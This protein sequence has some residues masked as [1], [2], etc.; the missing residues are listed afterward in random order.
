[1]P[2][3]KDPARPPLE[4]QT[5]FIPEP[6]LRYLKSKWMPLQSTRS[7][8]GGLAHLIHL[9]LHWFEYGPREA[10]LLSPRQLVEF[11]AGKARMIKLSIRM[12]STDLARAR[13]LWSKE[14]LEGRFC[15]GFGVWLP[16]LAVIFNAGF[17]LAD[18]R[19]LRK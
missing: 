13:E 3:L 1:M 5:V 17:D 2:R 15:G 8:G 4:H 19:L 6:L 7:F 10:I 16:L 11:Y 14:T 18:R 9:Q 12:R